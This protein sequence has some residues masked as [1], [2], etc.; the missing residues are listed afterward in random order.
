MTTYFVPQPRRMIGFL[1]PL[2][3]LGMAAVAAP[4]FIQAGLAWWP[5]FIFGL[6]LLLAIVICLEFWNSSVSLGDEGLRYRSVGYEL[7][8][9]WAQVHQRDAGK[10]T[11]VVSQAEPRL[12]PWLAPM[13]GVLSLLMPGRARY[14]GGL[15]GNIP[16]WYFATEQDDTVMVDF[17]RRTAAHQS[18]GDGGV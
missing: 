11:L 17:H 8:A 6:P 5:L 13:N 3:I 12:Y 2:L 15:M 18:S 16:L 10:T 1:F 9:T 14:A 4:T 7:S